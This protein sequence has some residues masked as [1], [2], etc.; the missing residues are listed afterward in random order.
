MNTLTERSVSRAAPANAASRAAGI[1]AWTAT[2]VFAAVMTVSGVSFLL[3]PRP[4]V[5][6]LQHLGYPPY[7]RA[8]LGTAK[9]LGVAALL[10]PGL[11]TLRE[12]AYAGFSIL[13]AGA[14]SSHLLS[15]DGAPR[16]LPAAILWA[17][18]LASHQLRRRASE[19]E[20]AHD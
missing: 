5:T 16:A 18:L 6:M 9:L 14:I 10:I 3:G 1:A 19:R 8:L 17:L 4:I 13:L 7:V 12:W 2:G 20:G 15:G 11:R